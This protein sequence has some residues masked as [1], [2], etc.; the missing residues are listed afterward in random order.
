MIKGVIIAIKSFRNQAF[1]GM[2]SFS[3]GSLNNGLK[4]RKPVFMRVSGI[5]FIKWLWFGS[6]CGESNGVISFEK[7]NKK[8][9]GTSYV[10]NKR[11][12]TEVNS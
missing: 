1:T 11:R 4:C 5:C 7:V 3:A 6:I 8:E 2:I 10:A 9:E 12:S